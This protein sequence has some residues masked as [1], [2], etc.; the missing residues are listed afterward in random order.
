MNSVL[1]NDPE[2][3]ERNKKRLNYAA[4]AVV[5]G[6]IALAQVWAFVDAVAPAKG[7]EPRQQRQSEDARAWRHLSAKII[8]VEHGKF[9]NDYMRPL[10]VV[11][12]TSDQTYGATWW[13][14]SFYLNGAP[15]HTD[16]AIVE[17]VRPGE[18]PQRNI[19]KE[20]RFD[21]SECRLTRVT[22]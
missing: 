11:T 20:Y 10:V 2:K 7:Q 17:R 1:S 4:A 18:T 9:D 12:N 14:C 3:N 15:I 13:Q 5:I 19:T 16:L 22:D 8:S 21:R 6:G